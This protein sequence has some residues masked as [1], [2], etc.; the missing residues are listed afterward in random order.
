MAVNG[1][2]ALEWM[3]KKWKWKTVK[4]DGEK[5]MVSLVDA[6]AHIAREY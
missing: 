4:M 1:L 2:F 5:M 3:R 6:T